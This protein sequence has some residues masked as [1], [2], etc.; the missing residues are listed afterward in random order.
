[1]WALQEKAKKWNMN[2]TLPSEHQLKRQS[3]W[4][5]NSESMFFFPSAAAD[6]DECQRKEKER[7]S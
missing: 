7:K 4:K 6:Y 3:S 2:E 1:M 5:F